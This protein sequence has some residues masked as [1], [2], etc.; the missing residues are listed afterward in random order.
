[1]SA[2]II[3]GREIAKTI[4]QELAQEVASLQSQHNLTPG[5]AVVL[6]GENPASQV[7]VRMKEKGCNE[8][9][10]YS[11]KHLL[12]ADAGQEQLLGLVQQLNADPKI[13]G[14]LVQLPLPEQINAQL[15]LE[16]ISPDKDV[17][18]FHPY[19]VGKLLVGEPAFVSC[20][21]FGVMK[22]LEYSGV[23]LKGKRA[24]VVGRSNIVG[25]PV[26]LLLLQQHATVT[27]CHSRTVDLPSVTRRAEVLIAAV[28]RPK[29]ITADMVSEG[30][31]VIDVGVNRLEDGTLA[32]DVDFETVKEKAAAIS[33]VPGGVGPMTIAML[34]SNTVQAAKNSLEKR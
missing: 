17:D 14:I 6:V 22:M 28:G 30:T 29:M 31:V 18:G 34:L 21:P 7:Y 20:T 1:M 4:R 27:I 13:H 15:V 25:K 10:I 32:G 12:P 23:Q 33:P 2:E 24:V 5:L 11:E 19:N 9:G 3:S 8:V 26:A 16:A